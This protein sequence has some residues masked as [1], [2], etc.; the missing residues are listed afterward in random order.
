[1]YPFKEIHQIHVA[2]SAYP[3][4]HLLPLQQGEGDYHLRQT[5]S[6]FHPKKDSK[7]QELE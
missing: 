5:D 2:Y 7:Y 1:M 6:K 4:G 3:K